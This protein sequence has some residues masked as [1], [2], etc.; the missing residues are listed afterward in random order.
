MCIVNSY[1]DQIEWFNKSNEDVAEEE[2]DNEPAYVC[3]LVL[4]CKAYVNTSWR[5]VHFC[6]DCDRSERPNR[7]LL[8]WYPLVDRHKI[9]LS[10]FLKLEE[11]YQVLCTVCNVP[12]F[13][14]QYGG[15]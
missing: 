9:E 15:C 8:D 6:E 5:P 12:L 10:R 7:R 1:A 14:V 3:L 13:H 2:E 4:P 11:L